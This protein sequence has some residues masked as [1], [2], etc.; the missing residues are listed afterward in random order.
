MARRLATLAGLSLLATRGIEAQNSTFGGAGNDGSK[1]GSCGG[2]G[3]DEQNT[4]VGV[5]VVIGVVSQIIASLGL[6][7][8]KAAHKRI[9][10][11]AEEG[12]STSKAWLVVGLVVYASGGLLN[13]VALS[14]APQSVVSA[15]AAVVLVGNFVFAPAILRERV[16]LQAA[17]GTTLVIGA[18]VLVILFGAKCS[19]LFTSL[20]LV[21]AFLAPAHLTMFVCLMAA[22]ISSYWTIRHIERNN[23]VESVVEEKTTTAPLPSREGADGETEGTNAQP[24]IIIKVAH[25]VDLAIYDLSTSK[26]QLLAALYT[27]ICSCLGAYMIMFSKFA[28]EM[29]KSAA[30]GGGDFGEKTSTVNTFS[31]ADFSLTRTLNHALNY[32]HISTQTLPASHPMAIL[33]RGLSHLIQR[34]TN[35]VFEPAA[36]AVS[37]DRCRARIP[38][39]LFDRQRNL[40][41]RGV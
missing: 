22:T 23:T 20:E 25:E 1:G 11:R 27:W 35:H 39:A 7:L 38:G 6:V 5:G 33:V 13:L 12:K 24:I 8:Q 10:R 18:T 31:F 21:E 32:A 2:D 4:G 36:G 34:H 26:G 28:G 15:L 37:T 29:V 17:F 9:A 40:R 14:M 30:S 19:P 16:T 41:G 3:G